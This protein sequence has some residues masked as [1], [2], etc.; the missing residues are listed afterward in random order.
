MNGNCVLMILKSSMDVNQIC[1]YNWGP[2]LL[3]C[4]N[5]TVI[6]WKQ[7]RTRYFRRP[8]MFLMIELSSKER[9]AKTDGFQHYYIGQLIQEH[10]EP[11]T[12]TYDPPAAPQQPRSKC[13]SER[14]SPI[15]GWND[16]IEKCPNEVEVDALTQDENLVEDPDFFDAY[17][18]MEAV[19]FKHYN[20]RT[21]IK[22]S[23]SKILEIAEEDVHTIL[24]LPMGPLEAQIGSTCEP[25]NEYTKLLQQWRTR[26][27]F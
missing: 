11:F 5:D 25:T 8:L 17:L 3:Q 7:N 16:P 13:A 19:A 9:D 6:E 21:P 26:R 15:A 12:S 22:F 14:E 24:V 2:Y 27:N 23:S 10:I 4:L 1:D 18:K 20:G